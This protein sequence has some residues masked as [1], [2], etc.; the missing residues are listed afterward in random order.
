MSAS[1][2]GHTKGHMQGKHTALRTVLL[3]RRESTTL[4]GM[5]C[6]DVNWKRLQRLTALVTYVTMLKPDRYGCA[7]FPSSISQRIA[8]SSPLRRRPTSV[9]GWLA[10]KQ[11]H[12]R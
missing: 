1:A 7:S 4:A 11:V 3:S 10:Q 2:K 6:C 8:G 12:S 5:M 9:G